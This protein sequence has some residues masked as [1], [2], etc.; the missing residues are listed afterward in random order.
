MANDRITAFDQTT[1]KSN[2]WI[3][4]L[5][6]ELGIVSRKEAYRILRAGLH[7]L[8]DQLD[9]PEAVHLSA[10]LPLLL[11]GVYFEGWVPGGR[12]RVRSESAFLDLFMKHH[13]GRPHARPEQMIAAV[14]SVLSRHIGEHE[15]EKALELMAVPVKSL[16]KERVQSQ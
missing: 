14:G 6:T 8:R 2:E 13:G 9:T 12:S 1:Q 10:Q 4:D 7:A 15:T 5:A 3:G 16:F 11:R